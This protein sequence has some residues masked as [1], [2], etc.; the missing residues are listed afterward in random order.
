MDKK[1]IGIY[2]DDE[3]LQKIRYIAWNMGR[4]RNGLIAEMLEF[5]VDCYEQDILETAPSIDKQLDEVLL[6]G[7]IKNEGC[8]EEDKDN[9]LEYFEK[10]VSEEPVFYKTTEH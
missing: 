10:L 8:T 7:G 9:A 5:S 6:G 1:T 2:V 3:V 4:S